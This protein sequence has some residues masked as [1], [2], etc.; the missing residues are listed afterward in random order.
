MVVLWGGAVSH[1][2]GTPVGDIQG[3]AFE[4]RVFGVSGVH[5]FTTVP[6]T[7]HLT[8]HTLHPTPYTLRPTPY[9]LHPTPCTLHF[10][11]FQ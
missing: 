7:M 8:P 4:R 6:F 11:F 1:E 5:L 3:G 10:S 2:R 9:T